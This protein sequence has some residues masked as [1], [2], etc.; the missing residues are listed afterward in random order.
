MTEYK[1]CKTYKLYLVEDNYLASRLEY[2]RRISLVDMKIERDTIEEIEEYI[3][4]NN[5]NGDYQIHT[6]LSRQPVWPD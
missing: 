2:Y 1:I 6:I 5:I 3:L 4:Y